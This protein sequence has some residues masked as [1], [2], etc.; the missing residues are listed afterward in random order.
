MV[1]KCRFKQADVKRVLRGANDAGLVVGS[2][3]VTSDGTI[4]LVFGN[5]KEDK[6]SSWDDITNA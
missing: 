1:V 5:D 2:I 6:P 4:R 3:E